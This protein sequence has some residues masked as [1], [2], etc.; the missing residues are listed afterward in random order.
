ML[1]AETL[2]APA[3]QR[4]L[5]MDTLPAT[6]ARGTPMAADVADHVILIEVW[7]AGGVLQTECAP[8]RGS[9]VRLSTSQG[10]VRGR[11]KSSAGDDYG[12]LVEF[13][14]D[15]AENWFPDSY[16]PPY[17]RPATESRE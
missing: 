10:I 2:S 3:T 4:Y 1:V 5:C 12:Y 9:R 14:V 11:V 6:F 16:R 8:E 17:L 15:P 7:E 13:S